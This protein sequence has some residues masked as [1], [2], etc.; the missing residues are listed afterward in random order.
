MCVR[1]CVRGG[2]FSDRYFRS[3]SQITRPPVGSR[4]QDLVKLAQIRVQLYI[5]IYIFFLLPDRL[6][7]NQTVRFTPVEQEKQL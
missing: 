7:M 5:Y 4:T 1:V 3:G 6:E 2:D